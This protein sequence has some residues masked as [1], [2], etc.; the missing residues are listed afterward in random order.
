MIENKTKSKKRKDRVKPVVVQT[1]SCT[2][3]VR[4]LTFSSSSSSSFPL[5]SLAILASASSRCA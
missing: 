1:P 5:P 4:E 2:F 3:S